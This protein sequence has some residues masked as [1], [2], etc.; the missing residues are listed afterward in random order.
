MCNDETWEVIIWKCLNFPQNILL[1]D[2]DIVWSQLVANRCAWLPI[3]ITQSISF[4]RRVKLRHQ[5]LMIDEQ[6]ATFLFSYQQMVKS[7][8]KDIFEHPERLRFEQTCE[9]V[10]YN[11]RYAFINGC[12][13]QYRKFDS[14]IFHFLERLNFISMVFF[15]WFPNKSSVI[16]KPCAELNVNKISNLY[17]WICSF[18]SNAVQWNQN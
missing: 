12:K 14:C 9:H 6:K 10:N 13:W 16:S 17:Q 5:S 1:D 18:S 7:L 4:N 2:I 3:K 11:L 8:C 15:S